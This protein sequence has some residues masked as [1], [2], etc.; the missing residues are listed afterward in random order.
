MSKNVTMAYTKHPQGREQLDGAL[1]SVKGTFGAGIDGSIEEGKGLL[2]MG[3]FTV[4][5]E[6]KQNGVLVP[7][8]KEYFDLAGTPFEIMRG[9]DYAS[10]DEALKDYKKSTRRSFVDILLGGGRQVE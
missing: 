8:L 2:Y 9:S 5:V 6:E 4:H 1:S 10:A 3:S 7:A